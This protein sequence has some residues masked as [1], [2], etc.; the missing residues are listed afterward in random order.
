M[1][2]AKQLMDERVGGGGAYINGSENSLALIEAM[3]DFLEEIKQER[4][5]R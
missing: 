2:I 3:R 4:F 5:M 1:Y